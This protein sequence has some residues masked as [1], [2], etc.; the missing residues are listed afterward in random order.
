VNDAAM[1]KEVDRKG[2]LSSDEAGC[3]LQSL[4]DVVCSYAMGRSRT[5]T[6]AISN[7]NTQLHFRPQRFLPIMVVVHIKRQH[8]DVRAK[9]QCPTAVMNIP[10]RSNYVIWNF[11]L[12][13]RIQSHG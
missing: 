13:C 12:L 6:H 2:T 8:L 1:S 10:R 5:S 3:V 11:L 9:N 4:K 7:W